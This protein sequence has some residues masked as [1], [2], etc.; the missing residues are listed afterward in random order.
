MTRLSSH[1]NTQN[2]LSAI[3]TSTAR[4]MVLR[5]FLIDPMRAYYQRQLESATGLVIRAVQRELEKLTEAGLLYRRLEGKRAYYTVDTEFP[6]FEDLRRLFLAGAD[7]QDTLRAVLAMEPTTHLLFRNKGSG[8][9][10]LVTHNGLPVS[11]LEGID[12]FRVET[13]STEE[14]LGQLK[15]EPKRLTAFLKSGEDL[16]GRRDDIVWSRIEAAGFRVEIA[17][18]IPQ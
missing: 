8:R 14:F 15:D 16:L 13:I 10:L 1:I 17:K 9:V 3:V 6:G 4:V 2:L 5:I 12:A 18:G 7:P 11:A